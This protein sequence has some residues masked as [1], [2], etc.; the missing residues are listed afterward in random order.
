MS[1]Y[2]V[3]RVSFNTFDIHSITALT[4]YFELLLIP[5]TYIAYNPY[6]VFWV[7]FNTFNIHNITALTGYFELLSTPL[8]YIAFD[9][10]FIVQHSISHLWHL[11][12]QSVCLIHLMYIVD[13]NSKYSNYMKF[14]LE[15]LNYNKL[16]NN[17][18]NCSYFK[19]NPS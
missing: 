9:P 16:W 4:A 15:A 14:R 19:L 3:F 2:N 6:N 17:S 11:Q 5:F 8:T 10:L 18:L 12:H 1:P 7:P 13:S